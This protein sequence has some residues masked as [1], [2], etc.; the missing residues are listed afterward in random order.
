MNTSEN[1]FEKDRRLLAQTLMHIQAFSIT[2]CHEVKRE[3]DT[4]PAKMLIE[5]MKLL[6]KLEEYI[7]PILSSREE[8]IYDMATIAL[9]TFMEDID[10]IMIKLTE[11]I[12]NEE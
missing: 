6:F 10:P 8:L 7:K 12:Q 5:N 9:S 11:E 3:Q 4:V 1:M 2:L